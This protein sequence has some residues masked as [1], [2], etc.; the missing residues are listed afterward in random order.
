[1]RWQHLAAAD[2]G[3][4]DAG[5]DR[6]APGPA[7]SGAGCEREIAK[8]VASVDESASAALHIPVCQRPRPYTSC[9]GWWAVIA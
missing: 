1:M 3:S 9:V 4:A 5:N 6:A 2:L 8:I 7:T